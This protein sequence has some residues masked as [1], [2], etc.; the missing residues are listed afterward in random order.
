MHI[1]F[2]RSPDREM[3]TVPAAEEVTSLIVWHCKFS[4]LSSLASF[5]KLKSLKIASYPD[6]SLE[7]LENLRRLEWL[8]ILHLPKIDNLEPL[9]KLR[10]LV[11]LELATTP[12]WDA[13]GKRQVVKS[14]HPLTRLPNL[15]YLALFGVTPEDKSLAPLEAASSLLSVR[16]SGYPVNETKR[17]YSA[18]SVTNEHVPSFPDA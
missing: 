15:A 2:M 4:T 16:V 12:G 13:S 7:P 17:F 18:F 11:S 6:A 5:T 14:L 3:P 8:S 1:E 9:A 10:N